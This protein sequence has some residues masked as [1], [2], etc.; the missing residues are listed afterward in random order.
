MACPKTD[1][2]RSH[3]NRGETL[4]MSFALNR[5]ETLIMS[6]ALNGGETPTDV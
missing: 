4:I 6:F 2:I 5:G 3:L 1:Y